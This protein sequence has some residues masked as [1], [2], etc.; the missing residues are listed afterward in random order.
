MA[1]YPI[2]KI[3]A[4]PVSVPQNIHTVTIS[5]DPSNLPNPTYIVDN[6]PPVIEFEDVFLQPAQLPQADLEFLAAAL[7]EYASLL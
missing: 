4:R 2:T 7:A 6:A 5:P 1:S 3:R